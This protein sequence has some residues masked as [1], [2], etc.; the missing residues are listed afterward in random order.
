MRGSSP[1]RWVWVPIIPVPAPYEM[2]RRSMPLHC[3]AALVDEGYGLAA[4]SGRRAGGRPLA[5]K[6]NSH[7]LTA[8]NGRRS[9]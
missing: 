9:R 2:R 5:E 4:P 6:T 7:C 1:V 3:N 8:N